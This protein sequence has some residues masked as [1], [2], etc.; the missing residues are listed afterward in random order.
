MISPVKWGGG[1]KSGGKKL[2]ASRQ[3]TMTESHQENT[4]ERL[5]FA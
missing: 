4:S 1:G 5:N 3:E 2:A